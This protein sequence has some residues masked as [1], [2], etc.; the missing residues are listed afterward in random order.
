MKK[1]DCS[2]KTLNHCPPVV[3]LVDHFYT[4]VNVVANKNVIEDLKKEGA[5]IGYAVNTEISSTIIESDNVF[6]ITLA[7]ELAEKKGTSQP[8]Y[9]KV[10]SVGTVIVPGDNT[11][12]E[13]EDL[14][15]RVGGS[16]L[17]SAMREYVA[18]LTV[19]GPYPQVYL[20]TI[21]FYPSA[22]EESSTQK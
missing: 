15:Q 7:V 4:E 17:Y 16:L 20:P 3:D 6:E 2:H 11:A 22:T 21:S 8:Y 12:E 18:M 5:S 13:K 10:Q 19:R 9:I 14:A 1:D